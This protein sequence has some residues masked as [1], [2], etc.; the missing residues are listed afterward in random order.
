MFEVSYG[1]D[2]K[3]AVFL[4]SRRMLYIPRTCPQ[5]LQIFLVALKVKDFPKHVKYSESSL[6]GRDWIFKKM[7]RVCVS[8]NIKCLGRRTALIQSALCSPD[9]GECFTYPE[10][11]P[12]SYKNFLVALKVKNVPKTRRIF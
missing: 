6:V 3:C 7:N 5:L 12:N 10:H 2:S 9:L 1:S 11:V 8:C 4:R